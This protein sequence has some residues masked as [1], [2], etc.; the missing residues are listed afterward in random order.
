MDV[1]KIEHRKPWNFQLLG[2]Q[3]LA[4]AGTVGPFISGTL[5]SISMAII[6]RNC[7]LI[8]KTHPVCD[9]AYSNNQH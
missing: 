5:I 4:S 3:K 1:K 7:V 6:K 2:T 8:V 9:P